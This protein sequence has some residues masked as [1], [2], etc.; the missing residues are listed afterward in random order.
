MQKDNSDIEEE[1]DHPTVQLTF[2]V[3]NKA[4]FLPYFLGLIDRLN[5]PKQRISLYI[6]GDHCVDEAL[7]ITKEWVDKVQDMYARVDVVLDGT[8]SGY[9][10]D[11]TPIHWHKKRFEYLIDLKEGSLEAARN[12]GLDFIFFVDTDNL[13]TNE[14]VLLELVES[15]KTITSPM[16]DCVDGYSNY[17]AAR[18]EKFFFKSADFY[19]DIKKRR[20]KGLF[21][22]P[23]VH[24]TFTVDLRKRDSDYLSYRANPAYKGPTDDI[25]IFAFNAERYGVQMW[26][27]NK[28][29]YGLIPRP[30]DREATLQD[31]FHSFVHLMQDYLLSEAPIVPSRFL[32]LQF[33]VKENLGFDKIYFIN[34]KRRRNRRLRLNFYLDVLGI[35]GTIV[36]AVDGRN[37]SKEDIQRYGVKKF[38][39]YSDPYRAR[40]LTMGEVGC[41]L[42][43]YHIWQ[44][45]ATNGYERVLI[46]EDD[47]RFEIGFK[48]KLSMAMKEVD[49]AG[50]T[51]S[52]DLIYLGRKAMDRDNERQVDGTQHLVWPGYTYWMMGYALSKK[53]AK[54][55]VAQQPLTRL[56]PTDEFVPIMFDQHP[57]AEWKQAFGPRN[58]QALAIEPKVCEPVKFTKDP[59]YSSDTENSVLLPEDLIPEADLSHFH[60]RQNEIVNLQPHLNGKPDQDY[61]I[62][63]DVEDDDDQKDKKIEPIKDQRKDV[64]VTTTTAAFN[65]Q[66]S[67]SSSSSSSLSS[68]SSA[69]YLR[70]C[71]DVFS[72]EKYASFKDRIVEILREVEQMKAEEEKKKKKSESALGEMEGPVADAISVEDGL[73]SS[74]AFGS[75]FAMPPGTAMLPGSAM[76]PGTATAMPPDSAM[77]PGS[78]KPPGS[79]ALRDEL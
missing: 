53:G 34:L 57:N 71:K 3:R 4:S 33:P 73:L 38:P 76:P 36:D 41:F 26:V 31:D 20:E 12:L 75:S 7:D 58:L 2:F 68:P 79:G 54:K 13:L 47:V 63:D 70:T 28:E 29:E 39:K 42:S 22:V 14:N 59:R 60:L 30:L 43:H 45:I 18:T 11:Q 66:S 56:V 77:P 51:N 48:E 64:V 78:A 74:L 67:S 9:R 55:L 44:D 32:E 49:V 27:T 37:L 21:A 17:W 52:W 5:Y 19:W 8:I 61:D 16:L 25:I 69:D 62:I 65:N 46:F 23:M 1:E 6:R 10:N 50:L 72:E 15:G 40:D 24:S 35:E